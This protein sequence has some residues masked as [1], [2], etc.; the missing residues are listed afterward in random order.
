M[1]G[2]KA[3]LRTIEGERPLEEGEVV[4]F[5]VGEG[6]AH[7]VV[8]RGDGPARILIVSEMRAPDV[9]VRTESQKIS[10]AGRPP[11]GADDGFHDVYFR[12]DAVELWDGEP[13]PAPDA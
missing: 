1:L 9:V 3:G 4:A 10:A 12:R 5:P 2:G 11:G 8:N 13:P 6:G 7:Q